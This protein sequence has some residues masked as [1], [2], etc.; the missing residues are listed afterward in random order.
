MFAPYPANYHGWYVIPATLRGGQAVDLM[1][2]TRDDFG[3]YGVSWE[4]PEDAANNY[5]NERWRKYLE[6][7]QSA[8]NDQLPHFD[9]Y[10]CREW[11]ARYVGTEQLVELQIIHMRETTLPDYQRTPP[12]EVV[13]REHSCSWYGVIG[14]SRNCCCR[15]P[16]GGLIFW[17]RD[18]VV[19]QAARE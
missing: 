6:R 2:V 19:R 15:R 1:P 7:L 11:N 13:L 14:V 17:V 3:I 18:P 16:E 10:I 5:K 12:R 8:E 4:K 9:R